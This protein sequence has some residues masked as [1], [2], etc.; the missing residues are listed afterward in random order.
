M[1]GKGSGG[2]NRKSIADHLRTGTYRK[3][4]HGEIK[5]KVTAAV[6]VSKNPVSKTPKVKVEKQ[7]CNAGLPVAPMWFDEHEKEA[8]NITCDLLQRKGTLHLVA[9]AAI[10]GFCTVYSNYIRARNETADGFSYKY[11]DDKTLSTKRKVKP[12]VAIAKDALNQMRSYLDS[13]G[14]LP[15]TS[16]VIAPP[17]D[18][19][20]EMEKFLDQ[21]VKKTNVE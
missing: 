16:V 14:L 21:A 20:S 5:G 15:K 11:I 17:D 9:P 10:Q 3:D 1:G 6:A 13:L 19:R 18:E 12:E 7:V 2:S 4:R 8:W